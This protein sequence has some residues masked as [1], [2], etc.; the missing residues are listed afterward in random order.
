MNNMSPFDFVVKRRPH[1]TRQG[2]LLARSVMGKEEEEDD[3]DDVKGNHRKPEKKQMRK[4]E[5]FFFSR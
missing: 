2:R 4:R 3:D 1:T 5:Y